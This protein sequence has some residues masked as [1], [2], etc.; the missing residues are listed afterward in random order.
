MATTEAATMTGEDLT[1]DERIRELIRFNAPAA[2]VTAV[3]FAVGYLFWPAPALPVL[4]VGLGLTIIAQRFAVR[5]AHL[6]RHAA[7]ATALSAGVWMQQIFNG[8]FAPRIFPITITFSTA[9][10][11]S[12]ATARLAEMSA[13]AASAAQA[14]MNAEATTPAPNNRTEGSGST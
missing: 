7:A 10:K 2:P 6:N 1:Q 4:G 8:V 5:Y 9:M 3:L 11:A 12:T 13:S 14:S